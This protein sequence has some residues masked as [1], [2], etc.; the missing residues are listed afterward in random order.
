MVVFHL[1]WFE[2][3]FQ[4]IYWDQQGWKKIEKYCLFILLLRLT[5]ILV[6]DTMNDRRPY[7]NLCQADHVPNQEYCQ[8]DSPHGRLGHSYPLCKCRQF[9]FVRQLVL[10]SIERIA[11]SKTLSMWIILKNKM[12]SA[13]RCIGYLLHLLQFSM[14]ILPCNSAKNSRSMPDFKCSPSIF[15]L[16]TYFTCPVSI[17][18]FSAWWVFDGIASSNEMLMFGFSPFC[19]SVQTPFGPLFIECDR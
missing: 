15:W 12:Y 18:A 16:T 1:G 11:C 6:I 19:S 9:V 2:A 10:E 13:F 7:P 8:V 4:G 14:N 3:L 17:R 5:Q